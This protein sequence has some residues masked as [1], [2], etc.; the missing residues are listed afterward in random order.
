MARVKRLFC[1]LVGLAVLGCACMS[2]HGAATSSTSAPTE[3]TIAA[4]VASY[5]LAVSKDK[6]RFMVGLFAQNGHLVDYGNADLDFTYIGT[7]N[8]TA[9]RGPNFKTKADF[10]PVAGTTPADPPT[11]PEALPPSKGRGVYGAAVRFNRAGYWRV[12]VSVDVKGMG[13][14]AASAAFQVQAHNQVP[15]VGQ[16][17]PRTDTLTMKSHIPNSAIDSRAHGNKPVPDPELHRV[18][19]AESIAR[20][21]P[22]LVVFATPVYC[23]S[24]FCGPTT[25]MVAK[26]SKRFADRAN[27]IH[28][29]IWRNYQKHEINKGAADWLYRGGDLHE[30]WVFLIGANGRIAARWDNVVNASEVTP[31]LRSLP[32]MRS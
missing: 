6:Q 14:Q 18:S 30:P 27:F 10:I 23:I 11:R 12:R 31:Y 22:A 15:A 7:K 9:S 17:A 1:G 26:L 24:R 5:D 4:T 28:V 25:D 21:Q 2:Q 16:Q 19:I 3:A 8:S 32:K 29:E 20:H 13:S